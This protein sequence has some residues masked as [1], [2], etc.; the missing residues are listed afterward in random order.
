MTYHRYIKI[1]LYIRYRL[2]DTFNPINAKMWVH[3][4]YLL[5]LKNIKDN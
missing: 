2:H 1:Q 5:S 3:R 4:L